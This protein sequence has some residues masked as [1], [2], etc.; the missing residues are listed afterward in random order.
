MESRKILTQ[1]GGDW[2]Y[3]PRTS[4]SIQILSGFAL[5]LATF[6]K[7]ENKICLAQKLLIWQNQ[8]GKK[9]KIGGEVLQVSETIW[10]VTKSSGHT[11]GWGRGSGVDEG[12]P[13]NCARWTFRFLSK[14][15]ILYGN[16]S[17]WKNQHEYT[18]NF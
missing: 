12:V 8:V 11:E 3:A 9:M 7:C 10:A 5:P 2:Q 16:V 13:G 18:Q 17:A 15:N 4:Y 6:A 14:P 1:A